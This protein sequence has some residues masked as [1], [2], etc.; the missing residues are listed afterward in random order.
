MNWALLQRAHQC[1]SP[2]WRSEGPDWNPL[3]KMSVEACLQLVTMHQ[4]AAVRHGG[5]GAWTNWRSTGQG[6][7]ADEDDATLRDQLSAER[8]RH[9]E[10]TGSWRLPDEPAPPLLPP[11]ERVIG[12]NT[13]KARIT[14]HAG[15]PL[16]GGWRL[17]DWEKRRN[18]A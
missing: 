16:F 18:R 8:A 3:P 6:A 4:N 7:A 13:A 1:L 10:A 2:A 14:W 5:W 17:D 11:L 15:V 9:Y 12:L